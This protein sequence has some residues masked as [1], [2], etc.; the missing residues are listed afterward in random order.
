MSKLAPSDPLLIKAIAHEYWKAEQAF[1]TFTRLA[2][3]NILNRN[4]NK[5]L[6]IRLYT[7]YGQFLCHLYE[8]YL[9][10]MERDGIRIKARNA[11]LITD[12][13]FVREAQKMLNI[14]TERIRDGRAPTWENHISVYLKTVPESFGTDFRSI[15]NR[16]THV[17]EKRIAPERMT[18][19]EF[20]K[21][22]H[23]FV[24]LLF[25]EPA[26]LWQAK[27]IE[28]VD[29]GEIAEFSLVVS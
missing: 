18:L 29:W 4:E 2:K 17:D 7:A 19:T 5:R 23:L 16:L 25:V 26:W 21:R 6:L 28:A 15:R 13:V 24:Y 10:C 8:F 20:Y 22:Y 3:E 11:S 14:R 1:D 9:G 27:D 12:K